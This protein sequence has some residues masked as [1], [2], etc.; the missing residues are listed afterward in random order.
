[1]S[2]KTPEGKSAFDDFSADYDAALAQGLS[3]SGET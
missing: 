1:M 2:S 3:V